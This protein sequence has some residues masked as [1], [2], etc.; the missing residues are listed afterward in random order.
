VATRGARATDAQSF[1]YRFSGLLP[2]E[3]TSTFMKSLLERLNE[4]GYREGDNMIFDYQPPH[5]ICS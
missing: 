2:G 4:L 3:N 1:S 5:T